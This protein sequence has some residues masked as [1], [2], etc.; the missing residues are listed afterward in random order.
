[1]WQFPPDIFGGSFAAAPGFVGV[2]YLKSPI[3]PAT[4]QEV[5]LTMFSNTIN[6]TAFPDPV[7]VSQL[8]RYL[9]GNL[10]TAAGDQ[11]CNQAQPKQQKVCYLYQ[12]ASDTRF[13]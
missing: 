9:S 8:W 5:G 4:S 13:Y 6:G 11:T 2:K 12:T 1:H 3:N 10:T 7:G